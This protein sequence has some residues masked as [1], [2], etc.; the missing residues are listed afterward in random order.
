MTTHFEKIACLPGG[1]ALL[2]ALGAPGLHALG[3]LDQAR[4]SWKHAQKKLRNATLALD[5]AQLWCRDAKA[6]I[7]HQRMALEK[8]R[9]K[10]L[11]DLCAVNIEF[12]ERRYKKLRKAFFVAHPEIGQ[13]LA[14]SNKAPAHRM[15]A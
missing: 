1:E 13:A 15:A 9:K 6:G 2:S 3:Q 11:F 4:S 8:E 14:R 10:A 7:A 12:S 5:A